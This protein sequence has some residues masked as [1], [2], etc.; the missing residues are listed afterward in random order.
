[1]TG[2][3]NFKTVRRLFVKMPD[4]NFWG[5]LSLAFLIFF[6]YNPESGSLVFILFFLVFVL[7][8]FIDVKSKVIAKK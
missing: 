8:S 1:M 2:D 6:V 3:N 4:A 5:I 7:T